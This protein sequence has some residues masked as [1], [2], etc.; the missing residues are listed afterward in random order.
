METKT[1][2]NELDDELKNKLDPQLKESID[3]FFKIDNNTKEGCHISLEEEDPEYIEMMLNKPLEEEIS[4]ESSLDN[5][6]QKVINIYRKILKRPPNNI[7]LI[8]H[9]NMLRYELN[10][11]EGIEKILKNSDEYKKNIN[12]SYQVQSQQISSLQQNPK[13]QTLQIQNTMTDDQYIN[14]IKKVYD[15]ELKREADETGISNYLKHMKKGMTEDQLRKSLRNSPEYRQNFGVYQAN[16]PTTSP[17]S[18]VYQNLTPQIQSA[19]EPVQPQ[20]NFQTSVKTIRSDLQ[21]VYCMMGEDRLNEIKPYIETVLPFIDKFIFIDGNSND[22]TIEYLNSLDKNKVEVY[23]HQWQDRFSE[24]RN[25]YLEKLRERN[26]NDWIVTSDSD[27][28]YPIESLKQIQDIIPELE[29]KGYNGI[30]VQ[31]EDIEVDDDNFN[32]IISRNINQYWK[33]LI[34]KFRPNL[35]Y[36]GE[37]HENITGYPIKWYKSNIIYQHRRSK[38]HILSRACENYFISNS[39]RYSERWAEMRY[40]CTK[41]GIL[42]F[43]DYWN[44]FKEHKL[45]K[46]V[47]DWIYSHKDDNQDSGDSELRETALLYFEVLPERIKKNSEL[48]IKPKASDITPNIYDKV[49]I[50]EKFID[51][52]SDKESVY[53]TISHG[54]IYII[55]VSNNEAEVIENKNGEAIFRKVKLQE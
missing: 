11:E 46:E 25:H 43:K 8:H 7:E 34:F 49:L 50:S 42:T 47:E 17:A 24:Q 19:Y 12:P 22:G 39:N 38:L 35:R 9:S 55:K 23:I 36:E 26:Y 33:P 27:E 20:I 48:S 45:P 29:A 44:L 37:P 3:D 18:P 15:E 21:L 1:P 52:I 54:D 51:T 5:F 30:K 4:V 14:I 13:V 16:I 2:Y 53:E 32:K 41:N 6:K 10:I 40:L 28:H 31:V